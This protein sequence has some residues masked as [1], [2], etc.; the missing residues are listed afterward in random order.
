MWLCNLFLSNSSVTHAHENEHTCNN[1]GAVFSMGVWATT[2]AKH[3][4]STI[5]AVFSVW[6]V[7]RHYSAVE[8][9]VVEC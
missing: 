9:S 8:G 3:A 1:G 4:S 6:S 5:E 2:I 7:P